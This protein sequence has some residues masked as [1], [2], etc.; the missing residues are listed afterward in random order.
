MMQRCK[1]GSKIARSMIVR[2]ADPEGAWGLTLYPYPLPPPPP[3]TPLNEDIR[4]WHS[5]NDRIYLIVYKL[6]LAKHVTF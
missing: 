2:M 4:T 5:Q 1:D 3:A 6:G